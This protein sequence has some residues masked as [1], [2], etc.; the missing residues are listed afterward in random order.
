MRLKEFEIVDRILVSKELSVAVR[1]F[2][3]IRHKFD[4]EHAA[5]AEAARIAG[6][7]PRILQDYLL[8]N[9]LMESI[10][11][12]KYLAFELDKKSRRQLA[13]VFAPKY[14]EFV[15]HHITY[16]FGVSN[17]AK[18]PSV[19]KS[20]QVIGYVDDGEGIEALVVSINGSKDRPDGNTYHITWSLDR[21][22]GKKPMHS[23]NLIATQ[24]FKNVKPIKIA[25]KPK[26][27]G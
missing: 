11:M 19:P 13:K 6:V 5:A 15:G 21:E 17:D 27:L 9:E 16:K 18:I 4:D 14:P 7:R 26:L 25:V 12:E 24:G 22:K 3:K 23:N 1:L 10:I 20:V 8:N 2:Q